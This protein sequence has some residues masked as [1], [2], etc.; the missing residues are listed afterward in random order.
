[1]GKNPCDRCGGERDIG[2]HTSK[3][4]FKH[5]CNKCYLELKRPQTDNVSGV[6]IRDDWPDT[7][8]EKEK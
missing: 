4:G 8:P 6:R 2:S 5:L 3:F 7:H 1:M